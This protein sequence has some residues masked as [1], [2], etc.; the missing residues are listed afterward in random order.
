[1]EGPIML[2]RTPRQWAWVGGQEVQDFEAREHPLYPM[3]NIGRNGY[4]SEAPL[5]AAV[6]ALM[7]SQK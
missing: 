1:M 7:E 3:N 5:W 6:E 2:L 4:P